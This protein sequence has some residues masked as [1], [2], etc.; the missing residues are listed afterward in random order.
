M[1]LQ[2]QKDES[3]WILAKK[4]ASFKSSLIAY[5]VVNSLLIAIWYF[6]SGIGSYFWP[7]WPMLGWGIGVAFQ[8]FD[9]YHTNKLF[10]V[11]EEYERLKR[12]KQL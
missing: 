2:Q 8:Y 5:M 10:S 6:T 11:E 3:L 12:K 4:R 9:A 1:E 7:I